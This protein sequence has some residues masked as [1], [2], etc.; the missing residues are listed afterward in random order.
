MAVPTDATQVER[1]VDLPATDWD[2]V[3]R[4]VQQLQPADDATPF[5]PAPAVAPAP[6]PAQ[7]PPTLEQLIAAR[8]AGRE[9]PAQWGWR[10]ALHRVTRGRV[11]LAPGAAEQAHRD[12]LAAIAR[13]FEGSRTVVVVNPKGGAH[14]TTAS[15]LLAATLGQHRGGSVLAWD[16]NETRGTLGWRARPADHSRTAV[17]L[18]HALPQLTAQRPLRV[19]DLDE[20]VRHQA[21]AHFDVLA[22]DEDAASAA[23]VDAAAFQRLHAAL[24]A[25]YRLVVVDTGNNMRASNWQAALAAADQLVVVSTV[26]EDTAQSAAWLADALRAAGHE[27][28]VAEAVTV[29]T[30]P[31]SGRDAAGSELDARIESHFARLTRTVV[32][33]PHDRSL[34]AG[35]PVDPVVLSASTRRAWER[36][37]AA[38]V[39]GL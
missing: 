16:N 2:R 22:S 8:P 34:V 35:G 31:A 9:L 38:V 29:L 3:R 14:K 33:V 28:L 36:V 10:G 13:P 15:L 39:C 6:T 17:D 12:D 37:A 18:L 5:Q 26:R 1:P 4:V 30:A 11:S 27:R 20:Y 19:G 21:W 24:A 32:R 7:A 23:L 25:Q